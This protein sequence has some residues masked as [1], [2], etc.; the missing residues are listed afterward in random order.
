MEFIHVL[1]LQYKNSFLSK[2]ISYWKELHLW[3]CKVHI[4]LLASIK[5][6]CDLG[7]IEFLYS[8]VKWKYKMLPLSSGFMKTEFMFVIIIIIITASL[9][10]LL[11]PL[12]GIFGNC[13]STVLVLLKT[14]S[15]EIR[16]VKFYSNSCL[17]VFFPWSIVDL[18]YWFIFRH[19]PKWLC[20]LFS[21]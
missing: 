6:V 11:A 20:Q 3:G 14:P 21:K 15:L 18:Q 12:R 9:L 13:I 2:Q 10:L 5:H 7:H 4:L 17:F 19:T 16:Y 1:Y 8:P